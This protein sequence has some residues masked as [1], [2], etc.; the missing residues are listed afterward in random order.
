MPL[1]QTLGSPDSALIICG[2]DARQLNSQ[3]RWGCSS[4]FTRQL[5]QA[6]IGVTRVLQVTKLR[7]DVTKLVMA[8]LEP[9]PGPSE[10]LAWRA[11][12]QRG[13]G[14]SR[15]Q[16]SDVCH[17]PDTLVTKHCS[18]KPFFPTTWTGLVKSFAPRLPPGK[19]AT[20][21]KSF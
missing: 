18:Q 20:M 16:N 3:D 6:G 17:S 8:E 14:Q 21:G 19:V 4:R 12:R 15:R 1:R 9:K 10:D 5:H 7:Y 13:P 11:S 2:C